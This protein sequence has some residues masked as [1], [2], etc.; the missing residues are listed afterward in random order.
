VI[1]I[2]EARMVSFAHIIREK[3]LRA[4]VRLVQAERDIK[5]AQSELGLGGDVTSI[6]DGNAQE[7][8]RSVT[9]LIAISLEGLAKAE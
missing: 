2:E 7:L 1:T 5:E 3:R 9:Q 8:L 6:A 4:V